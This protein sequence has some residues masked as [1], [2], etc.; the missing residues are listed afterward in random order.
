MY[1]QG[2]YY[3]YSCTLALLAS[4]KVRKYFHTTE[5]NTVQKY[6][7]TEVLSYFRTKVLPEVRKYFR[8]S[9]RK[10]LRR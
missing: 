7:S 9:V 4:T 6:G 10:Y 2:I 1:L 5:G 8:T 3:V